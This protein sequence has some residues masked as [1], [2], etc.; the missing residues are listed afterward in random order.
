VALLAGGKDALQPAEELISRLTTIPLTPALLRR[1]GELQP[2]SLRSLDAI[3][4]ATA[5]SLG[6][7]VTGFVCYDHSLSAAAA[8]RGL[9][10][11]APS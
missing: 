3:H 10:V 5:I 6:S 8:D 11:I 2:A 1:A 9:E 4:L 7:D